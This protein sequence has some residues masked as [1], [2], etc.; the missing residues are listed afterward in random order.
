[1]HVLAYVY[2]LSYYSGVLSLT[3]CSQGALRFAATLNSTGI[4]STRSGWALLWDSDFWQTLVLQMML[5][6]SGSMVAAALVRVLACPCK[7]A[8]DDS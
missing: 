5:R 7:T 3:F 4:A 8:C 2:G 1:M 6:C